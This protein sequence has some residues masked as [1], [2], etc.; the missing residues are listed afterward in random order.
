LAVDGRFV[1]LWPAG[2]Q[3]SVFTADARPGDYRPSPGLSTLGV[4]QSGLAA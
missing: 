4:I 1:D 2:K 3:G